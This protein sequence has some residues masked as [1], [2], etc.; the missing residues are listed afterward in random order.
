M[1]GEKTV[2]ETLQRHADLAVQTAKKL[3]ILVLQVSSARAYAI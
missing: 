2:L 3:S 1:D